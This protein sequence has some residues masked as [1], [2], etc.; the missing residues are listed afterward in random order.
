MADEYKTIS[1]STSDEHSDN[2]NNEV[3]IR[4]PKIWLEKVKDRLLKLAMEQ[5]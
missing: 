2:N 1:I 3:V 4:G 5:V